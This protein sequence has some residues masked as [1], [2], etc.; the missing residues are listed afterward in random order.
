MTSH[1][2]V[3][4]WPGA[5]Y[6]LVVKREIVS[7]QT[8][9]QQLAIH[10]T[11]TFGR[12]LFLDRKIQSAESDEH[13]YHESLVQPALL[14]HPNPRSVFIA[15]GG[16]GATLREVLRFPSVERALMVD[17]DGEA[18]AFAREHMSAWHRGAF[19][20]WRAQV[21]IDDARAALERSEEGFDAIVVDVTDPVSGGPSYRIFTEQFYQL[22]SARLNDGGVVAVQS[23]SVALPLVE[24]HAAVVK[25]LQTVFPI[26]RSYGAFVPAFGEPW[27]FAVASRDL[28]PA[29]LASDEVDRRLAERALAPGN[30]HYDGETHCHM[31][32]LPRGVRE[33][34]ARQRQTIADDRP[35]IVA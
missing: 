16:E 6:R 7:K 18:V 22:A 26:V 29:A 17:I 15:G 25:T 27:G 4:L 1:A 33:A 32:A 24:G 21:V 31:F 13:I 3:D 14:A 28:D 20:D 9:F 12:A 11:E 23:E 5:Q 10:D 8:A 30:R 35:L 34:I 2:T 19:D